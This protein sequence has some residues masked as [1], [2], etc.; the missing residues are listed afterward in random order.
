MSSRKPRPSE[1]LG[2]LADDWELDFMAPSGISAAM[3]AICRARVGLADEVD[4]KCLIP[5]GHGPNAWSLPL[6]CGKSAAR[7]SHSIQEHGPLSSI[8]SGQGA[9]LCVLQCCPDIQHVTQLTRGSSGRPGTVWPWDISSIPPR[10]VPISRASVG[11]FACDEH[12]QVPLGRADN[13]V[14]PG[15]SSPVLDD[16]RPTRRFEGLSDRLFTLAYRTL[17][18][19]ISQFRGTEK[20]AANA[21]ASQMNANNRFGVR[22]MLDVL[23]ELNSILTRLLRFKSGFDR[24]VLGDRS[25]IRLVHYLQPFRPLIPYVAS[26]YLSLEHVPVGGTKCTWVSLNVL[27]LDGVHWLIVSHPVLC[28]SSRESLVHN[29]VLDM[30]ASNEDVRR[31]YDFR[32]ISSWSNSYFSVDKYRSLSEDD[33][34]CIESNVVRGVVG[35]LYAKVVEYLRSSPAG[36]LEVSRVEQGLIRRV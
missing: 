12:D 9:G 15:E 28:N 24:R 27:F 16:R 10:E 25:A 26:E 20:E 22:N 29:S 4:P 5:I 14:I 36:A 2:A 33:R 31:L 23:S 6:E 1:I 32:A 7:D 8:A 34:V 13:L 21:L 17:L 11:H 3:E 30:A 35:D 19:R 18:F